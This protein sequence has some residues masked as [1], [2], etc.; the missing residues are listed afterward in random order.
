MIFESLHLIKSSRVPKTSVSDTLSES[1]LP[2]AQLSNLPFPCN[3]S[4]HVRSGRRIK[5]HTLKV[6]W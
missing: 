3:S 5:S 4:R 2:L 6:R 1:K